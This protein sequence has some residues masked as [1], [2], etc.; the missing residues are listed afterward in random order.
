MG[1]YVFLS[2]RH[3]NDHLK[4]FSMSLFSF[5]RCQYIEQDQK[6]VAFKN[7]NISSKIFFSNVTT[8]FYAMI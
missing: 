3:L 7:V 2:L 5:E 1:N 4:N 8:Y 6:H